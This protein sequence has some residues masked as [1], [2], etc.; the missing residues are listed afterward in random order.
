[1]KCFKVIAVIAFLL[2]FIGCAAHSKIHYDF[3]IDKI[4]SQKMGADIDENASL[5]T[6]KTVI[7]ER[8]V[9]KVMADTVIGD[10]VNGYGGIV[11]NTRFNKWNRLNFKITAIRGV[12]C[13]SI[14]LEGRELQRICLIEGN[15]RYEIRNC[16]GCITGWG[17]LEASARIVYYNHDGITEKCHWYIA[18]L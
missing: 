16:K 10:Q 17:K 4:S 7:R 3:V 2:S 14:S 18:G 5:G 9:Q 6:Y 13:T 11:H 12:D 8:A 1:M 15:Y